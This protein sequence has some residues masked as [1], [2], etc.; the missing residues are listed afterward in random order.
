MHEP[1][2]LSSR[3]MASFVARGFLRLD[4]VVPEALN[5]RFLN[6]IGHRDEQEVTDPMAYYRSV[7]SN[8]AIPVVAAGT[9]LHEAYPA[10]SALYDIFTL[11][12]IQG[13]VQSLVGRQPSFD[14]HFLH[15][16]LPPHFYGE[17]ASHHVSQHYHQD[18]TIDPR[19]TFDIQLMYFPQAVTADMGGTRFLPGSHLRV[20]S[21]AAIA[22]YQNV[23]GQ[24]HVVCEAGTVLIVHMGLWHGGGLNLSDRVRYMFKIR[25]CP[26][27]P[28]VRLWDTSD[29]PN[30]HHQQRPIFWTG[31]AQ[32]PADLHSILTRPEPWHEDDTGRLEAI[33]RIRL[34]RRLLGDETFDADY[35]LTRIDN[36]L[37]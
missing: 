9:P 35:W 2:R 11:P 14:H 28:Q 7:M 15:M 20:V 4:E 32:D 10:G 29:L 31:G 26:T 33:N 27:E 12:R 5:Q 16:T 36:E 30:D 25:L 17:Q 23:L 19:T 6:D 24:R 34:W 37:V 8:S 22:R 3:D 21:E 13:A 1:L 18:S